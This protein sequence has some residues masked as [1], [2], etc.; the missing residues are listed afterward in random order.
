[1][2]FD[3]FTFLASLLNFL[4]LLILLRVFLFKR[5][6][7]AMDERERRIAE[8]WDEAE[9]TRASAERSHEAY[10]SRMQEIDAE[11]QRILEQAREEARQEKQRDMEAAQEEVD[12]QRANWHK[13]LEDDQEQLADAI[14]REVAQ[15]TA[16]AVERTL[17]DLADA[18]LL[19]MMVRRFSR[20]LEEAPSDVTDSFQSAPLTVATS[21][22]L[23]NEQ[24]DSLRKVL[25]RFQ[26]ERLSF[27]IDSDLICGI[28]LTGG[29][30]KIAW[31][32][33]GMTDDVRRL[34][35]RRIA[36]GSAA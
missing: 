7:N 23:S 1:M 35:E 11:R 8:R 9:E 25:D 26:Y 18:E 17:E 20:K 34:V 16:Q 6:T 28:E 31:S 15:Q 12:Q 22:E 2:Q 29:G 30:K 19:E 24:K 36:G 14:E 3:W 27:Q 5:I 13:A 21:D 4:I 32:I 33:A 10:E